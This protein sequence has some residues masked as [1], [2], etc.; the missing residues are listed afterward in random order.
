MKLS[1]LLLLALVAGAGLFY[2][3]GQWIT[4]TVSAAV[5]PAATQP[6]PGVLVGVGTVTTTYS[7]PLARYRHGPIKHLYVGDGQ[8][9]RK[10][11]LLLK[12]YD[13]TFLTAPAAGIIT[14]LADT[15]HN[16]SSGAEPVYFF[17]EVAPFRLR[18]LTSSASNTLA[19]G[20]QVQVQSLQYPNQ[21]VTGV[22]VGIQPNSAARLLDLRLLTIGYEPLSPQ[23]QVQVRILQP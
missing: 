10:G 6:A 11:E 9:V 8:H 20:Q 19:V 14:Q 4:R 13:Y 3:R 5:P 21:V 22:V 18:L 7:F 15:A 23:A 1:S 17:T 12:Y 16:N 2:W